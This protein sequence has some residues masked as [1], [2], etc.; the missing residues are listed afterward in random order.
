MFAL[1][2]VGEEVFAAHG[3]HAWFRQERISGREVGF[4]APFQAASPSHG[5]EHDGELARHR[6]FTS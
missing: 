1:E 4:E 2:R 5:V 3:P 6:H